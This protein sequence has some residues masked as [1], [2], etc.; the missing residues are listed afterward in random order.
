MTELIQLPLNKPQKLTLLSYT[1]N[2]LLNSDKYSKDPEFLKIQTGNVMLNRLQIGAERTNHFG[3][4]AQDVQGTLPPGFLGQGDRQNSIGAILDTNTLVGMTDNPLLMDLDPLTAMTMDI[5]NNTMGQGNSNS[6]FTALG[7]GALF[8]GQPNQ[9]P[10]FGINPF[11]AFAQGGPGQPNQPPADFNPFLQM[12][13]GFGA[14]MDNNAP[15]PGG[16]GAPMDNNAPLPGGF[17]TTSPTGNA[18]LPG[19]FGR[20]TS[21]TGNAPL[22]NGFGTTSPTGNAPLP[23]GF[24]NPG[25]PPANNPSPP[26]G[27]ANSSTLPQD[28][29]RNSLPPQEDY[30]TSNIPSF[31][32]PND[33]NRTGTLDNNQPP[34]GGLPDGWGQAPGPR[35]GNDLPAN[36]GPP[37]GG[38]PPNSQAPPGFGPPQGGFPPAGGFSSPDQNNPFGNLNPNAGPYNNS[39]F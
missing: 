37:P 6:I 12:G 18:P 1:V 11:D 2:L 20:T 21:P 22:P 7:G 4:T 10:Q 28:D 17:G 39:Q 38:F 16:F 29:F 27:F 31:Q 14:P 8:T 15:L 33:F 32:P 19:G 23:A 35:G 25:L 24:G 3:M 13:G 34:P 9:L 5:Q 26:P 30:R 36:W